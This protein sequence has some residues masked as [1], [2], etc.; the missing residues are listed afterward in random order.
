MDFGGGWDTNIGSLM[1]N[2]DF[3]VCVDCPA[4]KSRCIII[5][6]SLLEGK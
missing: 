2:Q 5:P 6:I 4:N 3:S 1:F